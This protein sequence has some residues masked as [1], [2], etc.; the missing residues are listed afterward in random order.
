MRQQREQT[1]QIAVELAKQQG[2]H[3]L[4]DSCAVL[5]TSAAATRHYLNYCLV[6]LNA[7]S[8]PFAIELETTAKQDLTW[9]SS[10]C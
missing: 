7:F 9:V 6:N 4:F 5:S 8:V 3:A 10:C 1:Q 2:L